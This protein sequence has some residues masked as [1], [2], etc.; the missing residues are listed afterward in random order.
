MFGPDVP[1]S[2][3]TAELRQLV[4]GIRFIEKMLAHPVD[5]D[6]MAQD[7]DGM[8]Q[9]FTKSIVAKADL[10]AGTVLGLNH[11]AFKK[12]GNGFP[13]DRLNDLIGRRLISDVIADQQITEELLEAND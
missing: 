11:L 3:T 7:L 13:P 12:P 2:L 1:A 10:P 6:E 8:R 9:L 4:E 5:K